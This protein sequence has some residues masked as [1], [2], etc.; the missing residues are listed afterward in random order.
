MNELKYRQRKPDKETEMLRIW[1]TKKG[2]EE[3]K[4]LEEATKDSVEINYKGMKL[5]ITGFTTMRDKK[6]KKLIF[7]YKFKHDEKFVLYYI[8]NN[9]EKGKDCFKLIQAVV[10]MTGRYNLQNME[11]NFK[12]I[13]AEYGGKL[14]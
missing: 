11:D 5:Q 2:S 6:T 8:P 14:K 7:A 10:G 1:N 3:A 4:E 13:Y 12:S 9:N